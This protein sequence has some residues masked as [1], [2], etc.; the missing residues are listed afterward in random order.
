MVCFDFFFLCCSGELRGETRVCQ[1]TASGHDGGPTSQTHTDRTGSEPEKTGKPILHRGFNEVLFKKFDLRWIFDKPH[2]GSAG[3]IWSSL[4]K[5]PFE[6]HKNMHFNTIFPNQWKLWF[7]NWTNM[8][9]C[10]TPIL[11]F[12]WFNVFRTKDALN[13]IANVCVIFA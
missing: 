9:S 8:Y 2:G 1:Q 13:L 12:P 11:R 4:N 3:F 7:K 6:W 5:S 10:C